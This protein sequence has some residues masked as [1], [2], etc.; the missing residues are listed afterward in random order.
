[1][2]NLFTK[3]EEINEKDAAYSAA[4]TL[5]EY[6]NETQAPKGAIENTSKII[7]TLSMEA[8][9]LIVNDE[10]KDLLKELSSDNTLNEKEKKI[11]EKMK[12]DFDTMEKIPANEYKAFSELVAKASNSWGEAKEKKNFA[13]FAPD[14]KK[15]IEYQKKFAG[16]CKKEEQS[17]YDYC[18]NENDEG[19]GVE[20]CDEF[21]SKMKSTIVPLMKKIKDKNDDIRDDFLYKSYNIDKQKEF[22][23]YLAEY[24]GFDSEYG[25]TGETE[26]PFTT[27]LHNKDVRFTNHFHENEFMSACFSA[28]H[29]GGHAL[30][31]MGVSDDY[32]MT[33][34]GQID[35][36]AI[37]ESQSRLYEN[38]IGRSIEF[39]T[40]LWPKAIELFPEQ[41]KDVSLE[42][43]IKAINKSYPSLIRTEADELTYSLHI[44]IRYEI[45]KMMMED[46]I[47]IDSLPKIWND[48]YEE[49]LGVVPENDSEG[50]LQDIH[51]AS[52]VGYF[53]S[54]SVGSAISAQIMNQ[55]KKDIHVDDLLK[56]GDMLVIRNYLKE[57]IHQYGSFKK[58]KEVL[59][60][61]TG[62]EF[63]PQYYIDYLND[64]YKKLYNI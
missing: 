59:K 55:M 50:V 22:C 44:L 42:E 58:P 9:N 10:V 33:P 38:N 19:F 20:E 18:L 35:S 34:L 2:N 61:L 28:I 11:V 39:W 46:D 12:K 26:H 47:D 52:G 17:D 36:M 13:I 27:S 48:K 30:F 53:P 62:E 32:T 3:L 25:I 64:K 24:I 63:N 1:M 40:P 21:F 41:L 15:I 8:Y 51:W 49:Y 23:D 16:Y 14:L 7:A 6:D 31:E 60:D 45:E 54:Y 56:N 43:F 57:N 4:L 5:L 37:H 29:E